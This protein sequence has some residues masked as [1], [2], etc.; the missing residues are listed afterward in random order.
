MFTQLNRK[1]SMSGQIDESTLKALQKHFDE[2]YYLSQLGDTKLKKITPL[3]HYLQTGWKIGLD[4]HPD[5]STEFYIS[6]N[7]DVSDTGIHPFVH[8]CLHGRAEG[9]PGHPR[10]VFQQDGDLSPAQREADEDRACVELYFDREY[11]LRLDPKLKA[12][13]VDPLDHFMSIGWLELRDPNAEFSTEF[14]LSSNPDVEQADINPFVH[15][16]RFGKAEGRPAK[17]EHAT[18]GMDGG[19]AR[20][21]HSQTPPHSTHDVARSLFNDEY[22]L[23]NNPD[24]AAS[25]VDPFEHFLHQGWREGRNPCAWFDLN[26]YTNAYGAGV[27]ENRNPFLEFIENGA[28]AGCL[29]NAQ[30]ASAGGHS[31][32]AEHTRF[33]APS[34]DFEEH[35]PEI[36]KGRKLKAKAIAYYLPQFHPIAENDE[37]WGKG[38][39]EWTNIARGVSRF[40]DHYQPRIPRDLGF[41]N[42][43]DIEAIRAQVEL[44]RASGLHGFCFYYYWFNGKR[45][46]DT[47]LELLLQ[48]KSI[49][50]PFCIMWTNENWT[51]AWDGLDRE[52]LLAQDYRD[53]D[54]DALLADFARHMKD[55]RYITLNGRPLLF[56]Y[57]PNLIPKPTATIRRWRKKLKSD[58]GLRPL[59][60]MAQGFGDFDPRKFE[61]DGGIEFPPHKLAVGQP[62]INDQMTQLDKDFTGTI[63]SYDELMQRSITEEPAEFPLIR[64]ASPSWD[65]EARRPGRGTTFHGSTPEKFENWMSEL[66][67]YA[68]EHP[69]FGE[70]L[71]AINAWNEWA[72]GAYLEPDIH[73]GAAYLNS[74][75]RALTGLRASRHSQ[76][77]KIVIVGH[78]AYHHGAQHLVKYLGIE[79]AQ[80]FGADVHFIICGEGPLLEDYRR[81]GSCKVIPTGSQDELDNHLDLLKAQ[82]FKKA[83]VNTTVSGWTVDALKKRKFG[84]VCLIHELRNLIAE[85]KL[86]ENATSIAT[87]ADSVVF[88][89][90]LVRDNFV[91][92]AGKIKG[93][94]IVRP[95]GLHVFEASV[96]DRTS[97]TVREDFGIPEDAKVVL[98]VGFGDHRKGFDLFIQTAKMLCAEDKSYHFLWAGDCEEQFKRWVLPDLENDPIVDQFHFTN[99]Y[100]SNIRDYYASADVYFLTSREDPFPSVVLESMGLGVPVVGFQGA[101]GCEDIIRENGKIVPAFDLHEA[102]SAIRDICEVDAETIETSRQALSNI[103]SEQYRFDDYC[104][105]LLKELDPDFETVSVVL[106]N[107]NYETHLPDRLDSI[108]RQTYPVLEVIVLDD[109]SRDGSVDVIQETSAASSR[110][111]DLVV[112]ETNSGS[113][114]KQWK[115]GIE[116]ARGKYIWIAEADD[117]AT[118]AFL[119]TLIKAMRNGGAQIGFSDSWQLDGNDQRLGDTYRTYMNTAA[120]IFNKPFVMKGE[121]FLDQALSIKN[122][123]LNVSG[124]VFE[125]E[126]LL[127]VL[128]KIGDRLFDFNVAGD[129]LIYSEMCAAESKVA[130]VPKAMNGHRR[131]ASSVTHALKRQKHFDEIAFMQEFARE[132]LDLSEERLEQQKA[133]LEDVRQVLFP[134]G[135]EAASVQENTR[136][137]EDTKPQTKPKPQTGAKTTRRSGSGKTSTSR[138]AT[139]KKDDE[140]E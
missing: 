18:H 29:P 137:D 48:D 94:V 70:S 72:E 111:I 82:G 38:F 32:F 101:G 109:A 112:N 35:D 37:W 21:P 121:D 108:F 66:V 60:F 59:I 133:A 110:K 74:L 96:I 41:Y 90:R 36:C 7:A 30:A 47:P 45:L 134:D 119:G 91:E 81:I 34:V 39:T 95:Q 99:G 76:K 125:R 128:E 16:C 61:L 71:V 31:V 75:S 118:P 52:V 33:T 129:W 73:F 14:Y 43:S 5:F 100:V 6:Q 117:V 62:P 50:F 46:L 42:L 79:L 138:K 27:P 25:E 89:A 127:N 11:Y 63:L 24:V 114:F 65:N 28:A 23:H 8:F 136:A 44:A 19:P 97:V 92:A 54:E 88:P 87:M 115:K 124:V 2:G 9:R 77:E 130:Y 40:Q 86:E 104:A 1:K 53:E 122:V 56:I 78:D 107:Y 105:M 58:H 106:P 140:T 83:I 113:V 26:F 55:E 131:H 20:Q 120:H 139:T 49:D 13:G 69:V 116:R 68:E 85:Y 102:I 51:R 15:Y 64:T 123:I 22:Y 67:A 17:P 93:E 12:M 132:R 103:V 135:G 126:A 80:K 3:D 10:D 84:V 4:P 57:R 98:C